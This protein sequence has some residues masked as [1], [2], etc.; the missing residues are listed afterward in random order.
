LEELRPHILSDKNAR[1]G[2]SLR[3]AAFYLK[4]QG[5]RP[6]GGEVMRKMLLTT[7]AV[8]PLVVAGAWTATGQDTNRQ[9]GVSQSQ[10]S[11]VGAGQ[12]KRGQTQGRSEQGASKSGQGA[13]KNL[14]SG[15]Q[16]RTEGRAQS[17]AG[18]EN[19]TVGEGQSKQGEANKAGNRGK[20]DI[21]QGQNKGREGAQKQT[22]GQ[23]ERTSGESKNQPQNLGEQNKGKQ[24][25]KGQQGAKGQ[26]GTTGQNQQEQRSTTGQN[27]RQE[28]NANVQNQRNQ[29]NATQNRTEQNRDQ[30]RTTADENREQTGERGNVSLTEEQRTKIQQSVLSGR[31]VPRVD[32]VDFSL[33]V[34]VDV[35]TR[36]RVRAVPRE[37]VEIHPEWRGY[38]YFVVR[39]DIV[40]VD[41]SH[42]V[43]AMVP[44][45][46]RSSSVETRGTSTTAIVES[47]EEIREIQQVLLEK[48][49]FHGRV[50][51]RMGPET[52]SA[53]REFQQREGI[54]VTGRIDERTM[55]SLGI[56]GH[57]QG[58]GRE[59]A[60]APGQQ[61]GGN[62]PSA[63]PGGNR[64]NGPTTGQGGNQPQ[65]NQPSANPNRGN[66][67]TSGQGNQPSANPSGQRNPG[68]TSGQGGNQPSANPGGQNG[69]GGA[70]QPSA[71]PGGSSG[72]GSNPGQNPN[73]RNEPGQR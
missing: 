21:S 42:K 55:T 61:Q 44:V 28:P 11:G 19:R 37:L 65:G 50:D 52:M 10:G 12:E 57:T 63:N 40:I 26:Q 1:G 45:G 54:E 70:N 7:V 47:P 71:S 36:I 6:F 30:S 31:D 32:R 16:D 59:G 23:S 17:G 62:Q 58:Q 53:I 4:G 49:F 46:S 48:G 3:N 33:N 39:D 13:S 72:T 18:N 2:T 29:P 34:G 68:G 15:A 56:S 22:Q 64:Q 20:N 8:I 24:N 67:G 73:Q 25:P 66:Q 27:Q 51:G 35:P 14:S 60:N 43:V 9:Q 38:D 5:Q 41:H 69:Q